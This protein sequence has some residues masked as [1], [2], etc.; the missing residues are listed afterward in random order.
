[1]PGQVPCL[2]KASS[3][4]RISSPQQE[5][6]DVKISSLG[7]KGERE[8]RKLLKRALRDAWPAA[9]RFG[10]RLAGLC[11]LEPKD[12]D[13][14]YTGEDGTLYVKVRDPRQG[15]QPYPYSF[16]L[17]TLLHELT[18]LSY[19]GH[20]K[21][22]YKR[23][24]EATLQCGAEPSLRREVRAH[25]CG[26]L[27][28]AVCDNDARRARAL[29]AVMPEAARCR[30]PGQ[31][32]LPLEYAAHHGRVALT[33]LLLEARADADATCGINGVPP[34]A[35][36]AAQGNNK[37]MRVLLEAGAQRGISTVPPTIAALAGASPSGGAGSVQVAEMLAETGQKDKMS[38]GKKGGAAV[39]RTVSLPT[40][41]SAQGQGAGRKARPAVLLAGCGSLCI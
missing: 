2:D 9:R 13:V 14:G 5:Y 31:L 39:R 4:T 1:M 37:T 20:G 33:K 12:N 7:F 38:T 40:L 16:V 19:L 10:W 32:Q 17:A 11:E 3:D 24:S 30:P 6:S 28:N 35:R 36:A 15:G 26:E 22:F 18:H 41:P 8:V 27:L 23:L 25:I 21:G 34:L 29:L